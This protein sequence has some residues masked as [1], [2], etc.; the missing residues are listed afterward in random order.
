LSEHLFTMW[1]FPACLVSSANRPANLA[2]AA[3]ELFD[4]NPYAT[5]VAAAEVVA[6]SLQIGR[7]AD[8]CAEPLPQWLLEKLGLE[9]GLGK[10]FL[11]EVYRDMN[12]LNAFMNIDKCTFPASTSLVEDAEKVRIACLGAGTGAYSPVTQYL[13]SQGYAV[14][15]F[16]TLEEMTQASSEC[17]VCVLPNTTQEMAD[18]VAA[19]ASHE[20]LPFQLPASLNQ[21]G[22][23]GAGQPGNA[24]RIIALRVEGEARAVVDAHVVS[25]CY[26]VDLRN[27][28]M[29]LA[30]LLLG[31][32]VDSATSEIGALRPIRS[33]SL[34][35][36]APSG[37]A[38]VVV[39]AREQT[40]NRFLS[41]LKA[42]ALTHVEET[43]DGLK[44][45]NII[46]T[47]KET[48]AL[49]VVDIDVPVLACS[50]LIRRV[51]ALPT[52]K[53]AK[54]IVIYDTARREKTL[55]IIQAGASSFLHA[56]VTEDDFNAALRELRVVAPAPEG[57]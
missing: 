17:H 7:E 45:Y 9:A 16:A 39:H 48:V 28:D 31:H 3:P 21:E 26:P 4:T 41:M 29:L 44:A 6:K 57:S 38:V 35:G 10:E 11:D 52:Q 27:I 47:M 55:P 5:I 36:R 19:L 37:P 40:R 56:D 46:R 53:S 34:A 42:A 1:G 49:L 2:Q 43:N 54:F 14:T 25:P 20:F 23:E 24:A 30:C 15:E 50:E 51:R 13:L 18:G 33:V 8:C 22:A 12:L 32:P